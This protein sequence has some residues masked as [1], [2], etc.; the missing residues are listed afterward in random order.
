MQVPQDKDDLACQPWYHGQLS[1]QG[2]EALL[3]QDGDFLVRASESQ[4]GYPVISCRWRGKTLHFEVFR[5]TLRPRPGR[6]P[7]L[8]Q[9]EDERFASMSALVHSYMTR[10]QPLSQATGA[11]ASRPVSRQRP[12]TRSFSEN[13][14]TDSLAA[15]RPL[16]PRK[17][18]FSQPAN[19]DHSGRGEEDGA[20]AGAPPAFRSALHRTGSEPTLLK[21][22][23]HLGTM[24]DSLRAS[25][26]RLHMKAPSKP[27]RTPCLASGHPSAYCELLPRVPSAQRAT[28]SASCPEPEAW[29][30]VEE[31]EGEADR[32]FVRPH[33]EVSFCIPGHPSR[34]LGPQNRP[35][36]PTVLSTLRNLLVAHHPGSTA[37]HLLLVD[38][39]AV[40]LL[41]V[42]KS[43]RRAM[44]VASGLELLTLPHGHRLRLEVLERIETLALAGALAVLGCPGHLEERTAA[45]KG[46]VE[47][48][49]ALRPGATGDLLGLAGVMGA[50]LMPQVSRLE[51][52]W[53]HLRRNHT[54]A[55]LLFE[56]ELKP[57]MRALDESTGPCNPGEVALPHVAPVVRLM[58]GEETSGPLDES[59]DRLL[60]TLL[61]A[62][63]VARDAPR[64]RRAAAQ[65]LQG[66]RPNP[67]LREA[68]TTSFLRRLLWGSKGA[69]DTTAHRLEKF[70]RVLSILSQQLEPQG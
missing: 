33:S 17:W 12:L 50:L 63:Q 61:G 69:Q 32:C 16:R 42:S 57:L 58:E 60:R 43:Q 35:L 38:C 65:R 54:E 46:L 5:V 52:T 25:D 67:E 28:P 11:V 62:R 21:A 45:L 18:S 40:G 1:R 3:R 55:A 48:A 20:K 6:P 49:L 53:R 4:D 44:G 14:L 64:F 9:L 34:L 68:L 19:L 30:E 15:T 56:Q 31:E 23:P 8:Y 59:C 7:A 51:S 41:G 2:A 47:L 26:G 27:L 10:R 24:A 13:V 39:Q 66:F 70:Q 29:W 36:D 22:L 37:L